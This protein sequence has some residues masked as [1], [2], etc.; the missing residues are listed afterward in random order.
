M[1][2]LNTLGGL[3]LEHPD[4]TVV[5]DL[6]AR[7]L[8]LL[9]IVAASGPQGAS[10]DQV[11]AVLWP[12]LDTAKGSHNLSQLLYALRRHLGAD[13]VAADAQALRFD[14]T[15]L[16][17]DVSLLAKEIAERQWAEAAHRYRG[18]FLAGFYL[19]G[20]PEFER[21]TSETRDRLAREGERAIE[22]HAEAADKSG[23]AV[24]ARA[25]WK[26]LAELDP[27]NSRYAY[28]LVLAL[29]AG[30]DRGG[31]VRHGLA[32]A[33]KLK[34][35]LGS[36]PPTRLTDLLARLQQGTFV[37]TQREEIPLRPPPR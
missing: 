8:A 12:E 16:T 13:V 6:R 26:R 25:A 31:A 21:W 28:Q 4:G 24:E 27:L 32:H 29:A 23:D 17:A 37:S 14:Q 5:G 11:L 9:A 3:W 7:W 30:G 34:D 1:L 2:R 15:L 22:S 35:E 33:A 18:P 20:A 19:E 10:R 36:A